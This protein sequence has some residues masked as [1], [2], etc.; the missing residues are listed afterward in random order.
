MADTHLLAILAMTTTVIGFTRVIQQKN[1]QPKNLNAQTVEHLGNRIV[2]GHYREGEQLPIEPELCA[3]FGVSRP[4]VREAT[5]ILIAK[6]LLT[7]KPRVGTVVQQKSHWNLLD[8][9]VL[10][11]V[12]QSLPA[13][14][15]LDMLFEARMAIEPCAAEIAAEK[16]TQE[17]IERI[18][19]AYEDMALAKSLEA[20]IEPDLRFHQA[21]LDATQND[22]IRYIGHTLH[23]A[24][25]ISISL[26]TWNKDIHLQSLPRHKAVY[27]AIADKN[28][29]QAGKAA[30][31]LLLDSRKDFDKKA[32]K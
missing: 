14:E 6:G 17:D 31:A 4:I 16:A 9:D 2:Q 27:M 20:T 23:N 5:K 8:K 11:W 13:E 10:S 26:T 25:S 28:P 3:E 22:V 18:G 21:V 1:F 24:L 12:T 19:N 29:Q 7:S 32:E 30:R 15:F